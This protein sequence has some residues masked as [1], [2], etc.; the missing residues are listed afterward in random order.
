MPDGLLP[1]GVLR[2]LRDGE[3]DLGQALAFFGDHNIVTRSGFLRRS[4]DFPD[5]HER[6]FAMFQ[7]GN[8]ICPVQSMLLNSWQPSSSMDGSFETQSSLVQTC[9]VNDVFPCSKFPV[10]LFVFSSHDQER[11]PCSWSNIVSR[12]SSGWDSCGD[13][14][15]E[16]VRLPNSIV[17]SSNSLSSLHHLRMTMPEEHCRSGGAH[18]AVLAFFG[19]ECESRLAWQ[20]LRGYP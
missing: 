5:F 9:F 18:L 16:F 7:I 19:V 14:L 17:L 1:G 8:R 15:L 2:Y 20:F 6:S 10:S 11:S 4:E 3:V 13:T 12:R